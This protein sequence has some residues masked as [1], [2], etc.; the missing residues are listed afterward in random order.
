MKKILIVDDDPK[1]RENLSLILEI[2]NYIIDQACDGEEG[3]KKAMANDYD[4]IICDIEMPKTTGVDLLRKIRKEN[5][6][7]PIVMLTGV[8]KLDTA[9]LAMKLGAQDYLVKPF[10]ISK[11]KLSLKNALELKSLR[12]QNKILLEEN[13]RYQ[14]NL[15]SLVSLRTEQLEEAILGSLVILSQTVE[16]KDPYTRGHSERVRA[17]SL[18]IAEKLGLSDDEKNI[19]SYGALLHDIGKISIKD[20]ILLKRGDLDDHEYKIVMEHPQKGADLVS[21]I[22]FFKPVIDCIKFHHEKWDGSGYPLGLKGEEIPFLARIISVADTFDAMTTTRPYRKALSVDVAMDIL[23]KI[24]YEQLDGEI[25]DCFINNNL[26]KIDYDKYIEDN[27]ILK[28]DKDLR[29]FIKIGHLEY[30]KNLSFM[31]SPIKSDSRGINA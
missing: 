29:R 4:C 19:L 30:E 10:E 13:K 12:V 15:E 8:K 17:I 9:V 3:I 5:D 26:H 7:V 2:E 31:K 14:K 27:F 1:M 22:Q 23:K 25:V 18:K 6:I 16:L 11:L 28:K 20:D 24:R 21:N